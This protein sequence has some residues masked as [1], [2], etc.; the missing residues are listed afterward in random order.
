M[1]PLL[2]FPPFSRDWLMSAPARVFIVDD[3]P[4]VREWLTNLLRQQ[5]DLQVCGQ[6]DSAPAALAAMR[7]DVPD[8]AIIDLSLKAGSGIDLIK[9][10]QAEGLK[11][12]IVVLSMH[13]ENYYAERAL[14]AGASGYV[15]KR[16]SSGRIVEAIREVLRG[17][18]YA[19]PEV[20]ER[21][22]KRLIGRDPLR[23]QGPAALSDRELEV[24]RRMG[25]GQTTRQVASAMNI[26]VKTVQAFCARIKE[27][28]GLA[29]AA[30]LIREAVRWVD[31]EGA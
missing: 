17:R 18:L 24:F 19:A 21:M 14:R 10:L 2:H 25:Q 26:S 9:D 31:K 28:L 23:P 4:L 6:A 1:R 3:H 12:A 29:S 7:A 5:A 15:M 11:T 13:E 22:T 20:L 27:K 16:E 30:E 8:V